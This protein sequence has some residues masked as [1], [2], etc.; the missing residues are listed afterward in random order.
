[1]SDLCPEFKFRAGAVAEDGEFGDLPPCH[2]RFLHAE[3]ERQLRSLVFFTRLKDTGEAF[4][5]NRV[6]HHTA[7]R[8][9]GYKQDDEYDDADEHAYEEA[10]HPG[11]Y[12]RRGKEVENDEREEHRRDRPPVKTYHEPQEECP[13]REIVEYHPAFAYILFA[14]KDDG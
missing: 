2:L 13:E 9:D 12:F 10:S 1:M 11:T 5:E 3:G 7:E 8:E 4:D 14:V 6:E